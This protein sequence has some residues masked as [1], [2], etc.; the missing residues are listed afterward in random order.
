MNDH[1]GCVIFKQSV[2]GFSRD[3]GPQ[4]DVKIIVGEGLK[5]FGAMK[6]IINVRSASL[7]MMKKFCESGCTIGDVRSR[8][9]G[10]EDDG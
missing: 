7:V 4:N 9:F 1:G 8:K 2:N 3:G 10:Y 5:T 6:K